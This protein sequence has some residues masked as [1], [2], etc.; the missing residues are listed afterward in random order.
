MSGHSHIGYQ[1]EVC[2][3]TVPV[4]LINLGSRPD[5]LAQMKTEFGAAGVEFERIPAVDALDPDEDLSTWQIDPR[6]AIGTATL[7]CM[8]S[9]F[10]A[11]RRILDTG[12]PLAMV[13]EDDVELS[14][15]L[16]P[17]L[18]NNDWIP[19]GIGLVQCETSVGRRQHKRLVGPDIM[20]TP[21]QGRILRRLH[22]RAM[23]AACYLVT[24]EAA[25]ELIARTKRALPA[26]HLLFN[27]A[28]SPVFKDVGAAL[29]M[30]AI[31]QQTYGIHSS[32]NRIPAGRSTGWLGLRLANT[33]KAFRSNSQEV[34]HLKNRK[35]LYGR[36]LMHLTYLTRTLP[37][38]LRAIANG[39]R[40]IRYDF[41]K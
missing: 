6:V 25:H 14:P 35:P 32:D 21:V 30:P 36:M 23:G 29:L 33:G 19:K 34:S 12:V 15:D 41:K 39:A 3:Q 26:D 2:T 38:L 5:R 37:S 16:L 17:L 22:S 10:R 8:L 27:P 1:T 4:F 7:C 31:A 13:A 11:L 40:Y 20:A 28:V 9:H 18:R 24:R